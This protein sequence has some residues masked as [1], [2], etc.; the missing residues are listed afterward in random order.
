[1]RKPS[2][3]PV[4]VPQDD[5]MNIPPEVHRRAAAVARSLMRMPPKPIKSV[6]ASKSK[7]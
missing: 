6:K 4:S 5:S 1:M 2:E 3:Q 7:K